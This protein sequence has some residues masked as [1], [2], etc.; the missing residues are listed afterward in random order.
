MKEE[1][2]SNSNAVQDLQNLAQIGLALSHEH[3][4]GSLL[5]MIV[6]AAR[7]M[8]NADAGTLYI[9]D[10]E[11]RSLRFCIMQNETTRTKINAVDNPDAPIPEPVPLYVNGAPNNA[12]VSSYVALTGEPVKISDVYS[13]QGFNFSGVKHYDTVSGY[14]SQSML[15]IPMRDHNDDIIGILQLL[16]SKIAGTGKVT[17]FSE[18]HEVLVSSLV[19]CQSRFCKMP[20]TFVHL[21][22]PWQS[23]A[24]LSGITQCDIL[25]RQGMRKRFEVKL[26]AQQRKELKKAFRGG[27]APVLELRRLQILMMSDINGP[28]LSD[29]AISE[30]LG[31]SESTV[32]NMR[33]RFVKR[34]FEDCIKRKKQDK[35]SRK[36]VLDGH[37]EARLIALACSNPPEGRSK[38]TLRLLADRL[39]ELEIIDSLSHETVRSVLKKRFKAPSKEK[40]VHSS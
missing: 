28:A 31:C 29:A 26:T 30:N 17:D 22:L 18:R 8:T 37:S 6:N 38:W 7:S 27:R 32:V 9:L 2:S 20:C 40:L 15:V 12:N 25:E 1:N 39:V 13:A 14:R 36:K 19:L 23:K 10:S 5:E 21:V 16:N 33:R 34:G 35:P 4:L 24:I 3:Q 11:L